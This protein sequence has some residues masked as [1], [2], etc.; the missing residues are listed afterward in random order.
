MSASFDKAVAE[1]A[2]KSKANMSGFTLLEIAVALLVI[3]VIVSIG[4]GAYVGAFQVGG[5]RLVNESKLALLSEKV[6]EFARTRGRLPCPDFDGDGYEDLDAGGICTTGI[7]VGF[8]PYASM[9]LSRPGD[10]DRAIYGVSRTPDLAVSFDLNLMDAA[11]ARTPISTEAFVTGDGTTTNGIERCTVGSPV[12]AYNPAYVLVLA[13]E[14]RDADGRLVDGV[15][16]ISGNTLP[17]SG[18]CFAAPSR[19]SSTIFDDRSLAV[20]FYALKAKL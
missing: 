6:I 18:L 8:L 19:E 16:S 2:S 10:N 13:G 7:R 1:I 5:G 20:G 3:G 11:A 12:I 14:D 9:D 15:H 4:A 17:V